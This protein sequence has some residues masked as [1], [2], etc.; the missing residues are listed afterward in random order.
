MFWNKRQLN[1]QHG[2]STRS[3]FS[4]IC[5]NDIYLDSGCQ[6]LR[7]DNVIN[8]ETEYYRQYNACGHRVKYPWGEKVDRKV[9]ET[10]NELLKLV[11][12]T[13]ID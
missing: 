7:P 3:Y 10:R 1:S 6:T 13:D 11:A 5:D 12:K 9:S 2:N 8:A 4:F